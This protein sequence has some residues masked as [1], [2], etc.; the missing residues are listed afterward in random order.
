MKAHNSMNDVKNDQGTADWQ[1]ESDDL[2]RQK[3]CK[4][5]SVVSR[6]TKWSRPRTGVDDHDREGENAYK[7]DEFQNKRKN[8]A[9]STRL[10][11]SAQKTRIEN[12]K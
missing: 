8:T 12:E 11:Q 5:I 10:S 1:S 6:S 4:V 3:W 2:G 9:K 7:I